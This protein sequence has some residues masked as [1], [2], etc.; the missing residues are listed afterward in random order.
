M[1]EVLQIV[2][3]IIAAFGG[4]GFIIIGLSSYLGKLWAN[5]ALESEKAKYSRELE[6]LKAKLNKE[7]NELNK[8]CEKALYISK[9]QYDNEYKI[10]QEIWTKLN[11]ASISAL[12]LYSAGIED[13]PVDKEQEQKYKE[14]KYFNFA[15]LYNEYINIIEKYAPFYR[16]D[17]YDKFILLR[18]KFSRVGII[19]KMY[20]IDVTYN[21]SFKAVRGMT[22]SPEENIEVSIKIPKEIN[23]IKEDLL[24]GIREYL[25]SLQLK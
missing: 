2:A 7:I 24:N 23:Q 15:K 12:N 22:I 25:L 1:K 10:Y 8:S 13:V 5:I 17:F 18:D 9:V 4:A 16:K 21:L 6:E 19:Y 3:T 20:V 14:D 11:D